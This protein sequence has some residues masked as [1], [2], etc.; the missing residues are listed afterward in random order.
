MRPPRIVVPGCAHHVT[1]RGNRKAEVF[2]DD[3]DRRVYIRLM[4]G[5]CETY[6]V[7]VWAYCLM[8]N[9]VH[10]VLVPEDDKSLS[11]VIKGGPWELR[12]VPEQE[13]QHGRTRVAGPIPLHGTRGWT[14]FQRDRY[15]DR[16]P[17]KAGLVRRAESMV[18]KRRSALRLRSDPLL[19]GD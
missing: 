16:N 9:H 11:L 10:H 15:V 8:P 19:T 2:R 4:H 1:Q 13:I 17:L 7:A 3:S 6:H 18:V 5:V 12:H 14:L